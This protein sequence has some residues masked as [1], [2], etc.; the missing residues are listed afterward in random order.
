M[1]K[2]FILLMF[3]AL[4]SGAYAQGAL[5][6]NN[7]L[8][9]C[10][11]NV[12]MYAIAPMSLGDYGCQIQGVQ[13]SLAAGAS[14]TCTSACD[15]ETSPGW[16]SIYHSTSCPMIPLDFQWTDAAVTV[17]CADHACNGSASGSV[18]SSTASYN[19]LSAGTSFSGSIGTCTYTVMWT[20]G[21]TVV[22]SIY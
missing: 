17:K 22:I 16:S 1:K 3:A 18:T 10:S 7:G 14:Y 4:T 12:N 20:G 13:I 19:C 21:S 11:V 9:T 6:I 5:T 2:I 15:F 8:S